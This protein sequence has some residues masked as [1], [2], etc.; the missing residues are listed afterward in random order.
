MEHAVFAAPKHTNGPIARINTNH[1]PH[2][3]APGIL[4]T[5]VL[6]AYLLGLNPKRARRLP[7]LSNLLRPLQPMMSLQRRLSLIHI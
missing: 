7:R 6:E 5:F 3:I 1:A 4:N 2:A